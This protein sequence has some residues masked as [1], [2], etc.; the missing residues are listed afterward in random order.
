MRR[1][2][3]TLL[4]WLAALPSCWAELELTGR[5]RGFGSRTFLPAD[6]LV[7]FAD[8][9]PRDQ[10]N[11]DLRLTWT[12]D[13]GGLDYEVALEA[14][15]AYDT[16]G[17][18][19]GPDRRAMNL[20][21]QQSAGKDLG[22]AERL[23]RLWVRG[24]LGEWRI[25][26]GRQ[27]A[28]FGGGLVFQPMD[29]FNPFSPVEID[30]DFRS[31]DDMIVA[32]RPFEDGSELGFFAV[33]RR[34]QGGT[35]DADAGSAAARWRGFFGSVSTE[36]LLGVHLEDP[37]MALSLSGPAGTAIWRL[38]VVSQRVEGA[39]R[40]SGVANVD[41]SFTAAGKNLYVFGELY[42]SALG[43]EDPSLQGLQSKPALLRRVQR[44]ELFVI[45]REY[46]SLG[47]TLEWHPLVSQNLLLIHEFADHSQLIQSTIDWRPDDA[48]IWQISLVAPLGSRGEEFG[49]LVAG[50]R[51]DG[52][53]LTLGGGERVL[54]R[55]SRYF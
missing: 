29:L 16:A 7:R 49:R 48:S 11:A 24:A 51:P 5:V 22:F 53:T 9:T 17:Q 15:A 34:A 39:L 40:V 13:G 32:S 38:D 54:V 19:Y 41:W 45:G 23:D 2:L 10:A 28:S 8:A 36:A 27:A 43:L 3:G 30:R 50:F 26:L 6:D 21:L 47:A 42:R 25:T 44:G 1:G 12:G 37:L 55:W 20:S 4:L 18:T 46:G 31:G 14:G 52:D 35:P 33:A